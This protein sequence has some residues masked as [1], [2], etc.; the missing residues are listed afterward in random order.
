MIINFARW[1]FTITVGV[2]IGWTLGTL[3]FMSSVA[4]L[5]RDAERKASSVKNHPSSRDSDKPSVIP[6]GKRVTREL[7]Y[8]PPIKPVR[9]LP[10]DFGR[11]LTSR[12]D[13]D[14]NKYKP[15]PKPE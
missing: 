4:S 10:P 15:K 14:L 8:Q 2:I 9:K 3:G 13:A 5:T 6:T 7:K 1:L 12:Y 11:R